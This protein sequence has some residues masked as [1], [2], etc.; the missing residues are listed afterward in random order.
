LK[1]CASR[2]GS[3][4]FRVDGGRRT[5]GTLAK[6]LGSDSCRHRRQTRASIRRSLV[7]AQVGEL[8]NQGV[9][10]RG[11]APFVVYTKRRFRRNRRTSRRELG[12][13]HSSPQGCSQAHGRL[14]RIERHRN[15]VRRPATSASAV[16]GGDR[17]LSAI[18]MRD[19]LGGRRIVLCAQPSGPAPTLKDW[20]RTEACRLCAPTT[21]RICYL[22]ACL[23][24]SRASSG[25]DGSRTTRLP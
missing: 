15:P 23:L 5:Q 22:G 3:I 14:A 13:K 10:S 21:L 1:G 16:N 19:P 12:E 25:S 9:A 7:R 11:G 2:R 17:M 4:Y 24:H 18:N 6:Q 20:G 8:R